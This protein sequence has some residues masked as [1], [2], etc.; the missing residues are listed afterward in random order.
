M[1]RMHPV[2]MEG[3]LDSPPCVL[4]SGNPCRNDGV[5]GL[6]SRS[7]ASLWRTPDVGMSG[8]DEA[9]ARPIGW[10]FLR[11]CRQRERRRAE[12]P[13]R[14]VSVNLPHHIT[15]HLRFYVA[16]LRHCLRPSF[17]FIAIRHVIQWAKIFCLT[18]RRN[19][20]TLRAKNLKGPP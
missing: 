12:K 3:K 11:P 20:A 17:A 1:S 6:V 16:S 8:N 10:E 9:V 13:V 5:L 18:Q 19:D 15:P 14:P 2:A 4:D 7:G